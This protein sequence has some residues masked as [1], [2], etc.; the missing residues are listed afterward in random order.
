MRCP[1]R[2]EGEHKHSAHHS[3]DFNKQSPS[4]SQPDW[5]PTFS[6]KSAVSR[7]SIS[8]QVVGQS[9]ERSPLRYA[10]RDH[11]KGRS[12]TEPHLG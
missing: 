9:D 6:T 2:P 11:N 1:K 3:S 8:K 10:Q 12:N 5:M 4:L 7:H